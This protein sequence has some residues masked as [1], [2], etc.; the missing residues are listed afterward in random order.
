MFSNQALA[1]GTAAP[2]PPLLPAAAP[3]RMALASLERALK[4]RPARWKVAPMNTNVDDPASMRA[5][6]PMLQASRPL[7][8]Y[9]EGCNSTPAACFERCD[10]LQSLYGLEIVR[11]SWSSRQYLHDEGSD[12]PGRIDGLNV[13]VAPNLA[14][15]FGR[16]RQVDRPAGAPGAAHGMTCAWWLVMSLGIGGTVH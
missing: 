16:G 2:V 4:G 15:L 3:P 10:R 7:L 12:L 8:M 14:Q 13:E 9:L 11:F 6:L 5:L 1:T